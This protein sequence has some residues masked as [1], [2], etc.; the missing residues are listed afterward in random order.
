MLYQAYQAHADIMVPVRRLAGMAL[1]SVGEQLNGSSRP[2]VVGNLT[3]AYELIARAGLTH[4]RPHYGTDSIAING[5]E[6]RVTERSV[7]VTPFGTLLHF[8]K[9]IVLAQPRVGGLPTS[10]PFIPAQAGIQDFVC[11]PLLLWVPASAGTNEGGVL[12][13]ESAQDRAHPFGT[14]VL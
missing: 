6:V 13:P 4:E 5:R 8:R 7:E 11:Q 14:H 10:C 1:R 9:D 3:A 2:T 12:S